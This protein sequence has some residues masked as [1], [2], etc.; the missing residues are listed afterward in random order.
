[1]HPRMQS[2]WPARAFFSKCQGCCLR[3]DS[4]NGTLWRLR[5]C[6]RLQDEFTHLWWCRTL[7][8]KEGMECS[9]R[10][11]L[12]FLKFWVFL[13]RSLLNKN[14]MNHH[15]R[16]FQTSDPNALP[17]SLHFLYCK[18]ARLTELYGLSF[19]ICLFIYSFV[20][21]SFLM[22]EWVW[23]WVQQRVWE[24]ECE[25]PSNALAFCPQHNLSKC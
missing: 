12:E 16:T 6:L 10:K 20:C 21:F 15:R 24:S 11:S 2:S 1:M 19:L 13:L 9:S 14:L 22:L 7:R 17:L 8:N 5:F 18:K 4:F 3:P 25:L 23:E